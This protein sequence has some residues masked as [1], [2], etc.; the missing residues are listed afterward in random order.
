MSKFRTLYKNLK[1]NWDVLFLYRLILSMIVFTICRITFFILNKD[2]FMEVELSD[3]LKMALGGLKFDLVAILYTNILF[4]VLCIIPFKF[5]HN[6]TY[7]RVLKWIYI[8][9]N[10]IAILVNCID[11]IYFRFT[12]RRMTFS[13]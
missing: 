3:F 11:M 12:L 1:T 2:L 6:K 7:Q 8:V 5:R 9:C 10:S 13:I 4:I